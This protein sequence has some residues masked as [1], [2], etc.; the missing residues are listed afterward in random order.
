MKYMNR[1]YFPELD[2]DGTADE[3]FTQA[4]NGYIEDPEALDKLTEILHGEGKKKQAEAVGFMAEREREGEIPYSVAQMK[5]DILLNDSIYV[6]DVDLGYGTVLS[7]SYEPRDREVIIALTQFR[8]DGD[9]DIVSTG[10]ASL[11]ADEFKTMDQKGFM[12]FVDRVY[13]YNMVEQ[14]RTVDPQRA[15]ASRWGNPDSCPD[16]RLS[17]LA[18]RQEATKS[19]VS[20]DAVGGKDEPVKDAPDENVDL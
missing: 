20:Q 2:L 18:D 8:E 14:E 9:E 1:Y 11:P 10:A 5:L 3:L 4:R 13:A 17:S 6:D 16:D 12:N 15:E 7:L 19:Q